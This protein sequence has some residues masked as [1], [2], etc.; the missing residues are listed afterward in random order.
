M[1]ELNE[2]MNRISE[3][4]KNIERL[5]TRI[6]FVRIGGACEVVV[7]DYVIDPQK[8]NLEGASDRKK[9]VP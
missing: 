9:F 6:G 7:W 5:M 3:L 4:E 8:I 1:K 2:V